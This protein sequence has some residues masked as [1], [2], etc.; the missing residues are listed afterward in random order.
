MRTSLCVSCS[1]LVRSGRVPGHSHQ[2]LHHDID[3]PVTHRCY[4][5]S[6]EE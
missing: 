2:I 6:M 1:L 4:D 5:C 3:W